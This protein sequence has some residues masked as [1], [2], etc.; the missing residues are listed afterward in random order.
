MELHSQIL[1]PIFGHAAV[2]FQKVLTL[3][4]PSYIEYQLKVLSY[5]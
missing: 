3:N 2:G 1:M 5:I 4:V